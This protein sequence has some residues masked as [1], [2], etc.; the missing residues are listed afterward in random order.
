MAESLPIRPSGSSLNT[1]QCWVIH[2][3]HNKQKGIS[4][5]NKEIGKAYSYLLNLWGDFS[6][7]QTGQF[8]FF[9]AKMAQPVYISGLFVVSSSIFF[10]IIIN[11]T[12]G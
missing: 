4:I 11:K 1:S 12:R 7:R 8:G 9:V 5:E 10:T 6:F 2:Q 3:Q